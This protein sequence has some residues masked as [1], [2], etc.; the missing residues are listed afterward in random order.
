[1]LV[2]AGRNQITPAEGFR[3]RESGFRT[4]WPTSAREYWWVWRAVMNQIETGLTG[5]DFAFPTWEDM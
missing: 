5:S 2:Q 3:Y 1:M 4:S